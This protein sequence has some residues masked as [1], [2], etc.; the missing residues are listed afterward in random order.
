MDNWRPGVL[1]K[2]QTIELCKKNKINNADTG[3]IEDPSSID[4]HITEPIYELQGCVK[5][6]KDQDIT[7]L[8]NNFK[9]E[10]I[11]FDPKD[12][13][14][15]L[16]RSKT[17]VFSI[18]EN[19]NFDKTPF[20]GQATGK[21]TFGRLDIL[22]RLL[23]NDS[24]YY[25]YVRIGYQGPLWIEVTPITF[26]I[27]IK[28]GMSLNQLR[29][30]KG[31]PEACCIPKTDLRL[32]GDLI[33][34]EDGKKIN[35]IK[36]IDSLTLNLNEDKSFGDGTCAFAVNKNIKNT[37]NGLLD[38][39]INV[40]THH[41]VAD[42]YWEKLKPTRSSPL[43]LAIE[44]ERFYIL[45]SRE[46]FKLPKSVAIY[47]QAVTE[48]LGELRIHYAG[49]A[50][51]CFGTDRKDDK[52]APLIFEVRGHNIR[53]LLQHGETLAKL[54]YYFMS[55]DAIVETCNP[56]YHNQ[57]LTLSKYFKFSKEVK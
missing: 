56:S 24:N 46:R 57:E 19:L 15:T 5:P 14:I 1:N 3:L 6:K 29:V 21:S 34:D 4:L 27:K 7:V 23:T 53:A 40:E 52:G 33:L 39:T 38:L 45:R 12:E 28:K 22:T 9:K 20:C 47:C 10:L 16:E 18:R 8:C 49:F 11:R 2:E 51:P 36:K 43:A 13:S 17:Y 42:H 30:Y 25:D 35:D 55:K 54:K 44:P 32:W 31:E 48:N 26:S 50:H 41:I 37:K